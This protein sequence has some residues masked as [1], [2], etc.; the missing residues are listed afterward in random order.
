[1][2]FK[3][4]REETPEEKLDRMLTRLGERIEILEAIMFAC[5]N[6]STITNLIRESDDLKDAKENLRRT[7]ALSDM[8]SQAV[9]DIRIKAFTKMER[10]KL[11]DECQE[12]KA[13]YEELKRERISIET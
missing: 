8:Q 2:F 13:K 12:C 1:M 9:I 6:Y 10:K 4:K 7:Y 11:F 5:N 3:R